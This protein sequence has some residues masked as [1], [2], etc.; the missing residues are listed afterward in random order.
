[1]PLMNEAQHERTL[2]L[3]VESERLM[4]EGLNQISNTVTNTVIVLGRTGSGKSAL[5][6]LLAGKPL[7]SRRRGN[8]GE[9]F[10]DS[11]D[12]LPGITIGT[13]QPSETSIPRS[14]LQDANTVYWDCPGFE[15]NRGVEYEIANAF[16][17]KKLFDAYQT[18]KILIVASE[19]DFNDIRALNLLYAVRFLNTFFRSDVEKIRSGLMLV[20]SGAGSDKTAI[21]IQEVLQGVMDNSAFRL[22]N[23]QK[24]I[25]RVFVNNPIII[26]KKPVVEGPFDTACAQ[27]YLE[28]IKNLGVIKDLRVQVTVSAESR[29]VLLET[30]TN[31]LRSVNLEI[32]NLMDSLILQLQSVIIKSQ[33]SKDPQE[34]KTAV[35]GFQTILDKFANGVILSNKQ[36]LL[37]IVPECMQLDINHHIEPPTL[38][39]RNMLHKTE[40]FDFLEQFV[41]RDAR[42]KLGIRSA[43]AGYLSNCMRDANSAIQTIEQRITGEKIT[44]LQFDLQ[45]ERAARERADVRSAELEKITT[46]LHKELERIRKL[47]EES[48]SSDSWWGP[49][50]KVW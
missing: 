10:L 14:W 26:F 25:F 34:L 20:V 24:E 16:L 17:I 31:L 3:A 44:T 40:I 9:F 15:D 7:V 45:N 28:T 27:E 49:I 18:C 22:T 32:D 30:Y 33:G 41:E 11:P 46:S 39:L 8:K 35:A 48:S 2:E 4:M 36:L 29:L 43:I 5:I 6:N 13:Q 50:P 23:P 12:M 1:M 47:A 37:E 19:A 21:Q 42:V 38:I